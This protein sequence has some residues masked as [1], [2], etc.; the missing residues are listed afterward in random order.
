VVSFAGVLWCQ[1]RRLALEIRTAAPPASSPPF[2]PG[3]Y[4]AGAH[5][6]LDAGATDEFNDVNAEQ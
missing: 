2:A 4:G 6:R 5:F 1:A 3:P